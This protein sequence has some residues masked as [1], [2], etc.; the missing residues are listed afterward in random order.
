MQ[1][2][3]RTL[4]HDAGDVLAHHPVGNA[5]GFRNVFVPAA[6]D[7]GHDKGV[8]RLGWLPLQKRIELAKNLD[9]RGLPLRAR[10]AGSRLADQRAEVGLLDA[11]TA[12]K[13]NAKPSR[14][15]AQISA[16]AAMAVESARPSEQP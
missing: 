12:P 2:A 11:L 16:R 13:V 9:D 3:H 14:N 15:G 5:Q 4:E 10:G 7:D 8:G 6:F 1:V